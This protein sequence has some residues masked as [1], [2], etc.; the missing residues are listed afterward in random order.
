M[1]SPNTTSNA[2]ATSDTTAESDTTTTTGKANYMPIWNELKK[3]CATKS[4]QEKRCLLAKSY[5]K[6]H[7]DANDNWMPYKILFDSRKYTFDESKT[8]TNERNRRYCMSFRKFIRTLRKDQEKFDRQAMECLEHKRQSAMSL[9]PSPGYAQFMKGSLTAAKESDEE[10]SDFHSSWMETGPLSEHSEAYKTEFQRIIDELLSLTETLTMNVGTGAPSAD[11]SSFDRQVSKLLGVANEMG[12]KAKEGIEMGR[13]NANNMDTLAGMVED[14][15]KN[16]AALVKEVRRNGSRLD[17]HDSRLAGHDNRFEEYGSEIDE[18][19]KR[20]GMKTT[21]S[22]KAWTTA[23][24]KTGKQFD[25]GRLDEEKEDEAT[26]DEEPDDTGGV[27]DD[28]FEFLSDEENMKPAASEDSPAAP[29]IFKNAVKKTYQAPAAASTLL[30]GQTRS[31]TRKEHPTTRKNDPSTRTLDPLSPKT[32]RP[33]NGKKAPST[34]RTA[35][36]PLNDESYDSL[37]DDEQPPGPPSEK[38][39]IQPTRQDAP[40]TRRNATSPLNDESFDSLED[41]EQ[42]PGSPSEKNPFQPTRKEAPSNI[43]VEAKD[44]FAAATSKKRSASKVAVQ[45]TCKE[46]P[47]NIGVEAKDSFAAATSKK[48]SASNVANQVGVKKS[49]VPFA[50]STNTLDPPESP[51]GLVQDYGAKVAAAAATF[52]ALPKE[53]PFPPKE[54]YFGVDNTSKT[55]ESTKENPFRVDNTST[56]TESTWQPPSGATLFSMGR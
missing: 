38:N 42:P 36:S 11:T 46:A 22:P 30:T 43:P 56:A 55:T 31:T 15:T 10:L 3:Y 40:S 32:A 27:F 16:H 53:V 35:T 39:P 5:G 41:D 26:T 20:I 50:N 49:F 45:V 17:D 33:S 34:Q 29:R 12:N 25:L 8:A 54:N 21:A 47:S 24:A 28:S 2:T 14:N 6:I 4:N 51:S 44:S 23:A 19:K 9:M 48:R 1:S 18:I 13:Q 52:Q 37:E 7:E